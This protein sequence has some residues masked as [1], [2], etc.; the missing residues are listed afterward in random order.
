MTIEMSVLGESMTFNT[1]IIY[2]FKY[3]GGPRLCLF[4]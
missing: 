4:I 1:S 2:V 3:I